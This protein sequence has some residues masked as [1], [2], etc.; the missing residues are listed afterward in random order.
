ML[1]EF[2]KSPS[3]KVGGSH[4][5]WE[6]KRGE[7]VMKTLVVTWAEWG[8]NTVFAWDSGCYFKYTVV[9]SARGVMMLAQL[10]HVAPCV[11]CRYNQRMPDLLGFMASECQWPPKCCTLSHHMRT[12]TLDL[13]QWADISLGLG[14]VCWG[15]LLVYFGFFSYLHQGGC[16]DILKAL[17]SAER[18]LLLSYQNVTC[19]VTHV[20]F[21]V[22]SVAT[23]AL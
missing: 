8:R 23:H 12:L 10:A 6:R 5:P 11:L 1:A 16:A 17:S 14:F 15:F 22:G 7:V 20:L 3:S 21:L 13:L 2:A 4:Q 18:S 19:W 9:M